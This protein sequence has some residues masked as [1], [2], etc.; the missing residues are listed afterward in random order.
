MKGKKNPECNTNKNEVDQVHDWAEEWNESWQLNNQRSEPPDF[1]SVW[2]ES[3][4]KVLVAPMSLNLCVRRKR[5]RTKRPRAWER[6]Q[7][8]ISE[9]FCVSCELIPGP[10]VGLQVARRYL[11]SAIS[12]PTEN[13]HT[14]NDET[15]DQVTLDVCEESGVQ[16][17]NLLKSLHFSCCDVMNAT[18]NAHTHVRPSGCR[19]IS[20]LHRV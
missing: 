1:G 13:H 16:D 12:S 11:Q 18:L 7:V 2:Q 4:G 8:P 5:I 17:T 14:G 3:R 20:G 10:L 15:R 6:S 19:Q 9:E